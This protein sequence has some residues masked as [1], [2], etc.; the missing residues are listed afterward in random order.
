MTYPDTAP[1]IRR[2][3]LSGAV[4]THDV[5]NNIIIGDTIWDLDTDVMW[6]CKDN[7]AGAPIWIAYA[8]ENAV[9]NVAGAPYTISINDSVVLFDNTVA[10][11]ALAATLPALANV[12]EGWK[13]RVHHVGPVAQ[14]VDV[15]PQAGEEI[16]GLG[17]GNPYTLA[18]AWNYVTV[19]KLGTK[20]YR[21]SD[22]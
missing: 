2:L 6:I 15:T 4:P 13:V 14:P 19:Q 18:A 17:A 12:P 16:E 1:K 3:N 22:G 20:W 21:V 11:G 7:T 9:N 8:G 5:N 10:V